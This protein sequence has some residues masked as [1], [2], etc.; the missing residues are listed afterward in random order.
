[1]DAEDRDGLRNMSQQYIK[2]AWYSVRFGQ[3][4]N[5]GVHGACPLEMLHWMQLGKYKYLRQ[6]FFAQSGKDSKLTKELNTLAKL[7]GFYYKRQSDRDLPRTD[8]SKGL[9]GQGKLMA[10]EMSGLILVLCTVIRCTE[11]RRLI[12]AESRGKNR[13]L[14]GDLPLIQDWIM[15]LETMLSWEAWLKQDSIP[16]NEIRRFEVKVRQLMVLEKAIGK[17][18]TGMG[19]RTF[20]F[21]ASTHVADDILYFGVPNC[22]NTSSNEMHHKPDKTA[23]RRTQRR[24]REFDKQ[25]SEQIHTMSLL[26]MAMEELRNGSQKWGYLNKK[27][28]V[29]D[30]FD[31]DDAGDD[32]IVPTENDIRNGGIRCRYSYCSDKNCWTYKVSSRSQEKDS[33]KLEK[34][35][36]NFLTEVADE[37]DV[38]SL[39]LFT[40][41]KRFDYLFRATPLYL[42]KPWRDWAMFEWDH[43]NV[44]PGHIWI[45][46]DLR[47]IPAN[48]TYDPGIYAVIETSTAVTNELGDD[49]NGNPMPDLSHIL[50]P[51]LKEMKA[52]TENERQ[53]HLVSV[54]SIHSTTCMIPDHGNE[55]KNAYL[56]LRPR[57][58]WAEQFSSWLSTPHERAFPRRN[59][60]IPAKYR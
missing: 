40:E 45:F 57:S 25:C 22:V 36:C 2:N 53:F 59:N 11:G 41:H 35:L 27:S 14:L 54:S 4:N 39:D 15:L 58:E 31:Q 6:M 10:S 43:N 37:L 19:F 17:R 12:A 44:T 38:S 29:D 28:D 8:F 60:I 26:D 49:E 13:R 7:H 42:G 50:R 34:D 9:S 20:N 46:V 24:P 3:H 21:H 23:A 16:V 56:R 51:F 47:K 1:M 55:N 33:W 32:A 52:G 30:E 5:E 18:D 48:P